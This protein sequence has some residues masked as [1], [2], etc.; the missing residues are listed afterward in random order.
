MRPLIPRPSR[1]GTSTPAVLLAIFLWA[2]WAPDFSVAAAIGDRI[3][4]SPEVPWQISADNVAYDAAATTYNATGQVIIEKQATRLIADRVAFNHKAMTAVAE[5][6]VVLTVDDDVLTGQRLELNIEQETGVVYDGSLF[7]EE[8]HFYIRGQR[9]EKTGRETYRVEKGS[10]TTCDGD[11][12][13]WIITSRTLKVTVE[14][15]GRASHAVLRARDVPVLY[16]PY[17]V[18]PAK[19]KRQTGLLFPEVGYSDRKGFD[20]NQPLFWAINDSSDATLYTNY[21]EERGARIGLEYR[22]ALTDTSYGAILA[23]GLNDRKVDDGTDEATDKWGYDDDAYDRPNADRYWLRAKLDQELPAGAMARLDLDIVSDQDYLAEFREG[24]NGFNATRE[25]FLEAFGRDLDTYDENTRTNRLNISRSWS[26]FSLNADVLWNDNITNRRWEETDDTLQRLPRI[27]FD[28]TKQQAFESPFYWDLASEYT[29]FY[30]EDGERGHRADLY[31]RAYLPLKWKNYLSVEPSAGW[32]QTTWVMDR[33][34]DETL[35]Q[36]TYRQIYDA[37]LDV[38]T[39][40]SKIMG[41]PVAAVDRIR[42]SVKPRVV[43]QY[44]PDQDQS[45]LPDFDTEID[46]IATANTVT[47]SLTN[48]FTARQ[49]K[50]PS[51]PGRTTAGNRPKTGGEEPL[52]TMAKA[53]PGQAQAEE[54]TPPAYDY[55]RF[56]RFYL[57]QTYD[58]DA[59]KDDE[60]EPFSDLYGELD[61]SFGSYLS[62]DSDADFDTYASHFSSHNVAA[63]VKD[64]REDRLIIEHR[65]ERDENESVYGTVAVK[66]TGR[67]SVTGEYE[68]DLL[69]EKDILKGTGFLYTAQCWAFDFRYTNEDGDHSFAF[70]LN[71]M[72]IGGFGK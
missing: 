71:L 24:P 6:H 2:L 28:G 15:Y 68:R 27:E 66:L 45:D 60:P 41:A 63:V 23:E 61:L 46:R 5:G 52:S 67:L 70:R 14:G 1:P 22:Y 10:V 64:H 9:I 31:P 55:S 43:Y 36:T 7:L 42:H 26:R 59:A 20:W 65:Y 38:S 25:S 72:G 58:I 37:R 29:Y 32:R 16:V 56:C 34:E 54:T 33:R 11:R 53:V 12:P 48:T 30:R 17:I 40:F 3:A 39:E 47:Y 21:M 19:T 35:N 8:N 57:E 13:D 50:K 49:S 4:G 69:A 44:I 62:L 18:F 51:P